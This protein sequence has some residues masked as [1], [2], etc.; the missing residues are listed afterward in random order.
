MDALFF[1]D[2]HTMLVNMVRDFADNEIT[3]IAAELDEV[4]SFPRALV[5]QMAELGLMGIPIPEELGGAGMDTVAY[6][7]AVMELGCADASVAITMA[8]HTSLGTSPIVIAGTDKQKKKICSPT[9][10]R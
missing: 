7:A 4:E 9:G 10:I 6:A 3:P 2:E 1:T 8:A 5:N